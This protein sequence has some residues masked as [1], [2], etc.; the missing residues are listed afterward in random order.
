MTSCTFSYTAFLTYSDRSPEVLLGVPY[1]G[2]ID[3]WSLACVCAEMYLG[4][5]LFPGVS[6]HNQLTR[7][8]EMMGYPPDSLIEGRNGSKYFS[9]AQS[10][11]SSSSS[12]SNNSYQ[13]GFLSDLIGHQS[14]GQKEGWRM[15]VS[16][17]PAPQKYRLKTAEEYASDTNTEIP[18]LRKYL[19]YSKLDDVIMKCPLAN[20]ARMT[21]DQKKEEMLRRLCFLNFLEGLFK[22]NPFER[23]TAKQAAHHPFITNAV[24]QG[25]FVPAVDPKIN[26]RK[27]AYLVSTQQKDIRNRN[28]L[29]H[30]VY[31]GEAMDHSSDGMH[32]FRPLQF[33]RL[34]EPLKMTLTGATENELA[35]ASISG[36]SLHRGQPVRE[37]DRLSSPS[38]SQ[39]PYQPSSLPYNNNQYMQQ[40]QQQQ[41]QQYVHRQQAQQQQYAELIQT[42]PEQ[43]SA[44]SA[45][46][47]D[48]AWASYIMKE[49]AGGTLGREMSNS[50]YIDALVQAN[51]QAAALIRSRNSSSCDDLPSCS[52]TGKKSIIKQG[53]DAY[54]NASFSRN[55]PITGEGQFSSAYAVSNRNQ[56]QQKQQQQRPYVHGDNVS[57]SLPHARKLSGSHQR[58]DHRH[59]QNNRMSPQSYQPPSS[60]LLHN[61]SREKQTGLVEQQHFITNHQTQTQHP[62]QSMQ[63]QLFPPSLDS[64]ASGHPRMMSGS[65]DSSNGSNFETYGG[66]MTDVP[67]MMTDFGQALMRPDLDERRRLHSMQPIG[68]MGGMYEQY[69]RQKSG[70]AWQNQGQPRTFPRTGLAHQSS[71]PQQQQQQQSKNQHIQPQHQQQQQQQQGNQWYTQSLNK[72]PNQRQNHGQSIS[73]NQ[74]Q[75]QN[76]SVSHKSSSG[77]DSDA[78]TP[79]MPP[80]GQQVQ[81]KATHAA[82]SSGGPSSR[83]AGEDNGRTVSF[84][85]AN[86]YLKS[87][88]HNY[89]AQLIVS[90]RSIS[91]FVSSSASPGRVE[92]TIG[93][94]GSSGSAG[95]PGAIAIRAK[96]T[97]G[98]ANGNG[99]GV[100]DVADILADWDPF[101]SADDFEGEEVEGEEETRGRHSSY[102][103]KEARVALESGRSGSA[104]ISDKGSTDD[105]DIDPDVD[106]SEWRSAGSRGNS[107]DANPTPDLLYRKIV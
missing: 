92:G 24:F 37:T 72:I 50:Q 62:P 107:A 35:P 46:T 83:V 48:G 73:H 97:N 53:G 90:S 70:Q 27:L 22:M 79:E 93:R 25:H 1:N 76:Q 12:S 29:G 33:R 43:Y 45:S 18:V 68:G 71:F 31:T 17:S 21:A 6:Q 56:S 28:N 91:G 40:Q 65:M 38:Q 105:G 41:Q 67:M 82:S 42:P 30:A 103:K 26:E 3:M 44:Y 4:L 2:A 14:V 54:D 101:F 86:D 87:E 85:P 104:G 15:P 100:G 98:N 94:V 32:V 58:Y 9:K 95:S 81:S 57:G 96:M 49:Q 36:P 34:S 11:F 75:N 5:P 78:Q 106:E 10:A 52:M 80:R 8:I 61:Q 59:N 66:S 20:K 16:A 23:W 55:V 60:L 51:S 77:H 19:R 7:I 102:Q 88:T 69:E 74:N 84:A 89:V 64:F 99:K 39:M 63:S 47:P 13:S